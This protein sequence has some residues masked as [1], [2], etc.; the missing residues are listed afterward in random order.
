M[1]MRR[2]VADNCTH[3]S[4]TQGLACLRALHAVGAAKCIETWHASRACGRWEHGALVD[5]C[6]F[7]LLPGRRALLGRRWQDRYNTGWMAEP[8]QRLEP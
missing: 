2:W 4:A 6:V 8:Q 3:A 1:L 7:V 5:T